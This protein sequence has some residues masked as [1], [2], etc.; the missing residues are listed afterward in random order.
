[1]K[2][3]IAKPHGSQPEFQIFRSCIFSSAP[4]PFSTR[5]LAAPLVFVILPLWPME[6]GV[7]S[8]RFQL[9]G[10]RLSHQVPYFG[11][12]LDFVIS[13]LHSTGPHKLKFKE[14]SFDKCPQGKSWLHRKQPQETPN[15]GPD[16]YVKDTIL[17][18]SKP[19]CN[20]RNQRVEQS[21]P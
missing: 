15:D 12:L 16:I 18:F 9:C 6:E 17:K 3:Q 4:L 2:I 19:I 21:Q 8:W 10:E 20:W 13:S 11:Q 14:I 1:M 5:I 7:S